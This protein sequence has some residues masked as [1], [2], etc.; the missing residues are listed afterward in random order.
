M[1]IAVVGGVF[2]GGRRLGAALPLLGSSEQ[3]GR[4]AQPGQIREN[5]ENRGRENRGQTELT[6]VSRTRQLRYTVLLL[7]LHRAHVA[8]RLVP[9]LSIV[10]EF[11]VIENR[12]PRRISAHKIAVMHEFVL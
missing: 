3:A 6:R 7:E 5:R 4:C 8:Q 10:K 11:D 9:A 12:R 1:R 2:V